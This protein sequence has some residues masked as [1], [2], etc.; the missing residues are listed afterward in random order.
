VKDVT[1][2][3]GNS[4]SKNGY[5]GRNHTQQF[6]GEDAQAT[7]LSSVDKGGMRGAA[8]MLVTIAEVSLKNQATSLAKSYYKTNKQDYDFFKSVHESP[9][10]QTVTEAMSDTYNPKYSPDLYSALP[11]GIAKSAILDK[12]WF[13]TRRRTHRYAIGLGRRIDFDF[14]MARL[15]AVIGGWNIARRYEF[16]YADEHNNRRFD[17]KVEVANI[18]IGVGNIVREGLASSVS[19]LSSAYDNLGN[20]VASIGNGLAAYSGYGAGR[21]DTKKRFD[22]FTQSANAPA[23][24]KGNPTVGPYQ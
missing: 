11:G 24:S 18:G 23:A 16:T 14:A 1:T 2:Y 5:T 8:L 12:Q 3:V 22:K 15:H 13:E 6:A 9:I 4:T 20:T 21:E 10:V 19:N 17:R 7:L